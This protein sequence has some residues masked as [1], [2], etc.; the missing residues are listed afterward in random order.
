MQQQDQH[1][2]AGEAR[3]LRPQNF[4]SLRERTHVSTMIWIW[5]HI[6]ETY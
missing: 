5:I 6:L 2:D 4:P 3:P 1:S